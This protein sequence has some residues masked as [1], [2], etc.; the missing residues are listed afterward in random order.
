MITRRQ[1]SLLSAGAAAA[2]LAAGPLAQ[3]APGRR[4]AVR[5]VALV[6][7]AY[8]DGSSWSKVIPLL[9]AAGLE[10]IAVQNPLTSLQDDVAA[11][12]RALARQDGPTLLVAH[13]YGGTVTSQAG[14]APNVAGLVYVAA[15]APEAS[16]DFAALAAR[17]PSPP[18]THGIIRSGG[19]QWL[20]RQAFLHDFA[21]GV[22][23]P[24][25]LGLYAVQGALST[26]PPTTSAA[27]WQHKP[28]WYAVSQKDRTIDPGLERFMAG[29]MHAHTTEVDAGH[30][31]LVSHLADIAR[32]IL[33]AAQSCW[34]MPVAPVFDTGAS[35]VRTPTGVGAERAV[36]V[37]RVVTGLVVQ[38]VGDLLHAL[39]AGVRVAL[40]VTG[41]KRAGVG[42]CVGGAAHGAD[43]DKGGGREQER[44]APLH[45]D[46]AQGIPKFGIQLIVSLGLYGWSTDGSPARCQPPTGTARP[47]PGPCS[48]GRERS[49]QARPGPANKR[50][51]E[52]GRS[53][54]GRPDD[55]PSGLH[56]L[57]AT[58]EPP[59]VQLGLLL[60]LLGDERLGPGA[61]ALAAG[62][63]D[64]SDQ[65]HR[66]DL[67]RARASPPRPGDG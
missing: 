61:G 4:S 47:S 12:N 57:D 50:L 8:A 45:G 3:A 20:N 64:Q 37:D 65:R 58:Q 44:A 54:D 53:G 56:G 27:A 63:E 21:N 9:Q 29:R 13:S 11:T 67:V 14:L 41:P 28:S 24:E 19:F 17:F 48:P 36:H 16:E 23:E 6:H 18:V 32:L 1:F 15:R 38:R 66:A 10:A 34:P 46:T 26:A 33:S 5:H 60:L 55:D 52:L 51:T 25:A 42:H 7:G 31:S 39:D 35:A 40:A 62:F 22:P 2:S 59:V 43:G 49:Q 30:L